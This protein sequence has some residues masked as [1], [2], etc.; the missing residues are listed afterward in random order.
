MA[1]YIRAG[2]WKEEMQK[3]SGCSEG[4]YYLSV[5]ITKREPNK[6]NWHKETFRDDGFIT[7]I[8][9]IVSWV[10][11]YVH[12]HQIVGIRVKIKTKTKTKWF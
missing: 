6:T 3:L 4:R 1:N 12:T 11:A 2:R 9:V 10:Y 7:L 8:A 5:L